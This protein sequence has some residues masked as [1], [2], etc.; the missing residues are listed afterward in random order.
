MDENNLEGLSSLT[1]GASAQKLMKVTTEIGKTVKALKELD[2][3]TGDIIDLVKRLSLELSKA[4]K[5]VSNSSKEMQLE[6]NI[7]PD[8]R[9]TRK[10][11]SMRHSEILQ[12]G[13]KLAGKL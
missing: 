3:N 13:I 5:T 9:P 10:K 1:D 2:V 8:L 4:G 12:K 11:N 6:L 7:L